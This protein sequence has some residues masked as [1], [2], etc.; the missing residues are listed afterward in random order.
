MEINNLNIMRELSLGMHDYIFFNGVP[1]INN[2]KFQHTERNLQHE[3]INLSI[4]NFKLVLVMQFPSSRI[5]Q[6]S[7]AKQNIRQY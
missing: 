4:S 3:T 5:F 2:W 1:I 6:V 7:T